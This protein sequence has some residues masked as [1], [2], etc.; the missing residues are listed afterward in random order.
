MKKMCSVIVLVLLFW[1]PVNCLPAQER[2][3]RYGI[4]YGTATS[5]GIR[6][7]DWSQFDLMILYPGDPENDY[8]NLKDTAFLI[9]IQTMRD[10]G[11]KIFLRQD[12]GCERDV[13]G[14]Y[15]SRTERTTWLDF[16]KREINIFVRYADGIFFDCVGPQQG[17]RVYSPQF[18]ED[19]Q[20]L[21]DY[22]HYSR[23]EVII[24]NL[25][26][27]MDWVEAG[28]LNAIPYKTDYVLFEGA[29]SVTSDQY[30]DDFDPLS[31]LFFANSNNFEVLGLDFGREED[32]DRLMYCYCASRVFG[33]SGFYYSWD[34][35]YEG[36]SDLDLP[37]LG[38]P[39]ADYTIEG[40]LYTRE[41]QRGK[42]YVDFQNHRGWIEGEAAE[43]EASTSI[44]FVVAGFL[45]TLYFKK[46]K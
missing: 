19:V 16:K 43:E 14:M 12:I 46:R 42:V 7:V 41:F 20:E 21:V 30:S 28:E 26:A 34:N 25:W 40:V 13:G 24:G 9:L 18:G 15:Y 31:A 3:L 32:R 29:W 27:L 4:Y 45:I 23:G 5:K 39:L 38:L 35:F 10:N 6:N 11:V 8:K 2:F 22:A 37:E 17:R 1:V 36:V 44:V 33:F